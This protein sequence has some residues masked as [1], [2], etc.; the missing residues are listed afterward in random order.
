MTAP[1]RVAFVTHAGP[2][3]GLGHLG[4]CLALA[5]AW[6]ADGAELRFLLSP[7]AR[8]RARIERGAAD[9]SRGGAAR[10]EVVELAWEKDAAAAVAELARGAPDVV[11]VDSYAASP[12][13]LT[14]LRG[15]AG[16]V[17]AVDDLADRP[18]PVQVVVNGGVAAE[19][20][21]Y[22]RGSG[23]LFLLGPRY[24]LVDPRLAEPTERPARRRV[25]RVLVSL[26]G[27]RQ[28]E[29]LRA[30]LRAV[31]AALG[32]GQ[33][34]VVLG[35]FAE[36]PPADGNGR[37]RRVFHHDPADLHGLMREA[38]LA[39]AGAGVTLYELAAMGTP[40]VM[41]RMADNQ[42]PNA[43]GFERAGAALFA[44]EA[45]RPELEPALAA[46]LSRLVADPSLRRSIAERARQ[47]IDG[48]GALRVVREIATRVAA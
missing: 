43:S 22:D 35:P 8:A 18:L 15:A 9:V 33:A 41:I 5:A 7:D 20:L 31:D 39:I 4:R 24:A 34:D 30:A 27:G 32:D 48:G 10:I 19:E 17:V 46:A 25:S 28:T 11:V 16:R 26:G 37:N 45:G 36:A 38:D 21:G 12:G 2:A 6:A 42:A 44:G 1:L 13:F 47:L 29:T 14:S 40:A 23:A 3:I